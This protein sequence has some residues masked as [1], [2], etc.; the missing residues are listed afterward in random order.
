[1]GDMADMILDSIFVADDWWEE[2]W[3][4]GLWPSSITCKYC[5]RNG[6]FWGETPEGWRLFTRTG[7]K[8]MCNHFKEGSQ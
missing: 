7:K 1:M 5:G 6:F 3:D 4:C 2:D 8:H